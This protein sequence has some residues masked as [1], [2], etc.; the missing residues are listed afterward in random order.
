[1]SSKP[2][3]RRSTHLSI[4][5]ELKKSSY[6]TNKKTKKKIPS[7]LPSKAKT[8][9][10]PNK[11]ISSILINCNPTASSNKKNIMYIITTINSKIMG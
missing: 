1:M 2:R 11:K 3:A 4:Q 8:K 9:Y 10:K 6:K 5:I 7:M